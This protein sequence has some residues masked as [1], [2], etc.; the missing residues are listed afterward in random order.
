[1][2]KSNAISALGALAQE[3]RLD[4]FRLLVQKG[5]QGL[6]AG[7]IGERLGLPPPTLSF[8]LNQLRYA[9]LVS[10]RRESRSIIYTANYKTMNSLLTFLTENC[11]ADRTGIRA[12]GAYDTAKTVE[13]TDR[14][15]TE[16]RHGIGGGFEDDNAKAN[17]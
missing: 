14:R 2:K 11:C 3:S 8:H 17:P 7:D 6:P 13:P 12:A 15:A 9:G 10:S 16:R 1:M 4:I 5:P